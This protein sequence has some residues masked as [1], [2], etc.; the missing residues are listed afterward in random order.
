MEW[1]ELRRCL[2]PLT[3]TLVRVGAGLGELEQYEIDERDDLMSA[4]NA[5]ASHFAETIGQLD[6]LVVKPDP[7]MIY[8]AEA[9]REA[10]RVSLR[11]APLHVGPLIEKH[12]WH[13]KESVV[14]TSATLT[15]AG[16]F[17]YLRGRLNAEGADELAVG[18][19]FNYETS[20]LLLLAKDC[21]EPRLG[22]E[23]QKAVNSCL[24]NLCTATRGR[25]LALFTS[26]NSPGGLKPT[27]LAIREPLLREGIDVY[28]QADGSSRTALLESF[29]T[30]EGAVLLGTK[31]FWEGVDVPGE[32]LSVLVIVKLPFD[33]P[34][35]PIIAARAETFDNAFN[36]YNLP[37]AI[38]RFRQGFGR[39]IRSRSD[40]G[41]VVVLDSRI[42]NKK[43][44]KMFL[45]S[46]PACTLRQ[47]PL[48][49]IPREAA[50]WVDG[51]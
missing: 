24:I 20:T 2:A 25:T 44:G 22:T 6:G 8:W 29:K 9:R 16:D 48:A 46:L 39:L 3:E 15:T 27:A 7:L 1:D 11:A 19:P 36:D 38:L 30:S 26:Y 34:D 41:V 37:E 23:Y 42:L 31:S 49:Q 33:R 21:P 51:G 5:A 17:D 10:D 13:A 47:V 18:S 35:D 40:R 14:L 12:L 28:D 50:R 43:Y 32:A 4:T 45:D